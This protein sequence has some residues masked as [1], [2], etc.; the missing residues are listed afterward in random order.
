MLSPRDP[1]TVSQ[2][3]SYHLVNLSVTYPNT[4]KSYPCCGLAEQLSLLPWL[5]AGKYCL[6]CLPQQS[7]DTSEDKSQGKLKMIAK[8]IA[9]RDLTS[10]K[11]AGHPEEEVIYWCRMTVGEHTVGHPGFG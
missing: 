4:R 1:S 9:N 11:Q 2:N 7:V 10:Q 6:P 5:S 3:S 8:I